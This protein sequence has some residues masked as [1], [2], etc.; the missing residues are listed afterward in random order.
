MRNTVL[1]LILASLTVFPETIAMNLKAQDSRLEFFEKIKT[2]EKGM[3]I[4]QIKVVLGEPDDIWTREDPGMITD[5]NVAIVWCFGSENH[6]AFPTLGRVDFDS[7]GVVYQVCGDGDNPIGSEEIIESEVR[8]FLNLIH[9]TPGVAGAKWDPA[10]FIDVV[11][12]LHPIGKESCLALMREYLRVSPL[13][14]E[15]HEQ[16][17]MLLRVLH[18]VP[19]EDGFFP[20][21]M[22]G[23]LYPD[24]LSDHSLLPRFPVHLIQDIPVLL[25]N[26]YDY[27]GDTPFTA[28]ALDWYESNGVWRSRPLEPA[29]V[30]EM[31]MENLM[32]ETNKILE[33]FLD[34]RKSK[35]TADMIRK[36][37]SHLVEH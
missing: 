19:E 30:S 17:S 4:A 20:D 14:L 5:P 35:L 31:T 27:M 29:K 28:D 21:P 15:V 33:L 37:L 2:I 22:L 3:P 24:E 1:L 9:S 36:Q 7:A 26:G 13:G 6:L 11:N 16:I 8:R 25:V 32:N 10:V 23:S 12:A 34:E 18:E